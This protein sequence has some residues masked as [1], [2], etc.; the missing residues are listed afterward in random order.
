MSFLGEALPRCLFLEMCYLGGHGENSVCSSFMTFLNLFL[1]SKMGQ[2]R[3]GRRLLE[4]N[5]ENLSL[6]TVESL[7]NRWNK[8][9][10]VERFSLIFGDEQLNKS[11][12]VENL[13]HRLNKKHLGKL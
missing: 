5:S 8:I 2:N 12:P 13:F 11:P 3:G 1:F 4:T 6:I 9:Q 7:F 10:P